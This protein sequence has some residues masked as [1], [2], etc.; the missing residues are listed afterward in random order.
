LISDYLYHLFTDCPVFKNSPA[1]KE[2]LINYFEGEVL[3][4]KEA[5]NSESD[6]ALLKFLISTPYSQLKDLFQ[7]F[8][9]IELFYLVNSLGEYQQ[10]TKDTLGRSTLKGSAQESTGVTKNLVM[11]KMI[12]LQKSDAFLA[13]KL[14]YHS[15]KSSFY[16]SHDIDSINGALL[17][18]G[19]WALKHGRVDVMWKIFFQALFQR[20][21]WLNMDLIMKTESEHGFK[22]A[23]YWLVNK[24]KIDARQSNA[25]YYIDQKDIVAAIKNV[26]KSGWENG[27]HKS[28][29][30]E[31]FK[32]EIAKLPFSPNGNRYHYL[33]FSIPNAWNEIERSGLSSDASLGFAEHYGFRNNYG[34][35]FHP[36]NVETGKA[37]SFLEIPLNVMDGTFERYMK[38]PVGETAKTIVSFLEENKENALI[39]ILWHN[40]F[41]TNYKFKGYIEEYKKILA[42]LY[43]NKFTCKNLTQITA[44]YKWKI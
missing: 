42:Y 9:V 2:P 20:P 26:E 1:D 27:L 28:I 18:D 39:S 23:F 11:Q 37:Y 13:S 7:K 44:E 17:Q 33:K 38:I 22:S 6:D 25:D 10:G 29:S 34:F 12:A 5:T 16:L 40:T 30:N 14:N 36:Y 24:G 41:F 19:V 43:E 3:K 15:Q 21:E 35:P 32:E 31:N 8:P 4:A